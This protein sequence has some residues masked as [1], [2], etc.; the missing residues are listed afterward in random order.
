MKGESSSL[1]RVNLSSSDTKEKKVW[2]QNPRGETKSFTSCSAWAVCKWFHTSSVNTCNRITEPQ[3]QQ[4]S[5]CKSNVNHRRTAWSHET[6][7]ML[8]QQHFT[9]QERKKIHISTS[10]KSL[11]QMDQCSSLDANSI[12]MKS[13]AVK[14]QTVNLSCHILIMQHHQSQHGLILT[15]AGSIF[16]VSV[17]S[18]ISQEAAAS[19]GNCKINH[20]HLRRC[21]A[22]MKMIQ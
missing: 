14:A 19:R 5:K 22:K 20:L 18:D 8:S 21:K 4:S 15:H 16:F 7:N 17:S 2:T 9:Q 13:R 11:A 10:L 1:S 12:Q 6:G 3:Q